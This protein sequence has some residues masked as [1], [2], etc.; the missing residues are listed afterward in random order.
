M[1]DLPFL[2]QLEEDLHAL[3]GKQTNFILNKIIQLCRNNKSKDKKLECLDGPILI[4]YPDNIHNGDE[5]SLISLQE[6]ISDWIPSAFQSLHLLPFYPSTS[7]FGF[8]P[9]N[10]AKV[11][12]RFGSWDDIRNFGHN[13]RI[14]AD[15]ILHHTSSQHPW[16]QKFLRDDPQYHN[17]YITVENPLD[18]SKV[19]KGRRTTLTTLFA[20]KSAF[21]T[22]FTRFG[23]DQI[24]LN[25]HNPYVLIELIKVIVKL[26]NQGVTILRL[27]SLAYA[28]KEPDTD[29]VHLEQSV[30]ILN[31]LRIVVAAIN[32][33]I[34]IVPEIDIEVYGKK[35]L[36]D[37]INLPIAGYS[38]A[39]A[40]LLISAA[41]SGD[42]TNLAKFLKT[43]VNGKQK[44]R[45][46][47]THDGLFLLP[48]APVLSEK[49]LNKLSYATRAVGGWVARRPSDNHIY[50]VN[51]SILDLLRNGS[52]FG[53]DRAAACLFIL[54]SV[55]GI[56]AIFLNLLIGTPADY[57]SV[58]KSNDPRAIIRGKLTKEEANELIATRK[59][60]ITRW[61][62]M[63][64]IRRIEPALSSNACM[65][66]I[67]ASGGLL[68]IKRK[69]NNRKLLALVNIGIKTVATPEI[70]K[71]SSLLHST[72]VSIKNLGS[73]E[74]DWVLVEN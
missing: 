38:F 74:F 3:Y 57:S 49:E 4:A 53:E 32:P 46:L 21:K 11:D 18:Y 31:I 58:T 29:C 33:G 55:A 9:T 48:Y 63:L 5:P 51:V 61:F 44:I 19:M 7:D 68:I 47:S 16:F 40:P 15:L 72:Q 43:D 71:G 52:P 28:W 73:Y 22:V 59:P 17:F 2:E 60:H 8:S 70:F 45:F 35:Y 24:D 12:S 30:R 42:I 56:P 54:L 69:I 64:K 66:I 36:L 41:L 65:D 14:M 6:I 23:A 37:K 50:E 27:D 39:F 67:Y 13:G 26:I 62:N 20:S 34:V 25:Y 1:H 10:H